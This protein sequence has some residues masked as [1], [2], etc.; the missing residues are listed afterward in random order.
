MQLIHYYYITIF[1]KKSIFKTLRNSISSKVLELFHLI[2]LRLPKAKDVKWI[3]ASSIL[4]HTIQCPLAPSQ[5]YKTVTCIWLQSIFIAPR[6]L[7][8]DSEGDF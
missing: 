7:C 3:Q 6:R 8:P 4:A 2:H 5:Y 1:L